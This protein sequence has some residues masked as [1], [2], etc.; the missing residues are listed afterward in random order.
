MQGIYKD[1]INER[2]YN[3]DI[4]YLE[5]VADS[6]KKERKIRETFGFYP[7]LSFL[8]KY[9]PKWYNE[10]RRVVENMVGDPEDPDDAYFLRK[11][12]ADKE[13]AVANGLWAWFEMTCQAQETARELLAKI[14]SAIADAVDN[15]KEF[16]CDLD[17]QAIDQLVEFAKKLSLAFDE[18]ESKAKK[19]GLDRV[20]AGYY[21]KST[22]KLSEELEVA[23]ASTSEEEEEKPADSVQMINLTPHAIKEVNSGRTFEP[24]GTVAR[25]SVTYE[26]VADMDGGIPLYRAK[27]GAVEGLP[28]P[29]PGTVYI[30]SGLVFEATDRP[31]V[32]APGN[33]VRDEQGRPV[34]CDGFKVKG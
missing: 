23:D 3:G 8:A 33:L 7:Y 34:G 15:G 26:K 17:Q 11:A 21:R 24:S 10:C 30:V 25:V 5:A 18:L 31:D 1:E 12:T 4:R 27:Y 19:I 29:Q 16:S 13:K 32:I 6:L 20:D 22:G 14:D 28:E 9:D 2:V